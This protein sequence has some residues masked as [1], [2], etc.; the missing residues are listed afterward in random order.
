MHN[1]FI[2]TEQVA[3]IQVLRSDTVA[4]T[5]RDGTTIQKQ[6]GDFVDSATDKVCDALYDAL[7]D[8]DTIADYIDEDDDYN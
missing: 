4:L 1:L 8:V 7:D 2:N 5:M 6:I 3:A